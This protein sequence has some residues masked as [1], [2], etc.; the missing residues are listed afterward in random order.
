MGTTLMNNTLLVVLL[1]ACASFQLN[2]LLMFSLL[3]ERH[4]Q[5]LLHHPSTSNY[6]DFRQFSGFFLWWH[7]TLFFTI[8]LF[9][10]VLLYVFLLLYFLCYVFVEKRGIYTPSAQ[11]LKRYV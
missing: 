7:F 5:L 10:L 4:Y 1:Y 8:L 6:L 11:T 9:F 3:W 2:A